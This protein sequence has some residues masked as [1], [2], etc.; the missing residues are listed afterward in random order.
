MSDPG[1]PIT[2]A[3]VWVPASHRPNWAPAESVTMAIRPRSPTSN[4]GA[5]ISPPDGRTWARVKSRSSVAR[6]TSQR[7]AASASGG[8]G[9]TAATSRPSL[10]TVANPPAGGADQ[11]NSPA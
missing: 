9:R 1:A 4:A 10:V 5:R 3:P 2:A 6:N 8:I 7:D 11:P